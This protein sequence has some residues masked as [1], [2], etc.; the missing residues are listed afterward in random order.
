MLFLLARADG[1]RKFIVPALR[2][3]GLRYPVVHGLSV[4]GQ[5]RLQGPPRRFF[6]LSGV[7]WSKF[8]LKLPLRLR[9]AVYL[10]G[11]RGSG[12]PGSNG[13]GYSQCE[14]AL[15]FEKVYFQS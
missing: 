7:S 2:H 10:C 9:S 4:Q 3:A 14:N 15:R 5:G 11:R 12:R 6:M 1:L 13:N 8:S